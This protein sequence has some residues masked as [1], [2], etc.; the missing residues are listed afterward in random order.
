MRR[1]IILIT[2]AL[3][4]A[5]VATAQKVTVDVVNEPAAA[6]FRSLITQT[7]KNFVYSSDILEGV[8]VTVKAKDRPLKKVLAEMF[9]GTGIEWKI[10]GDNVLLK[11]GKPAGKKDGAKGR[12]VDTQRQRLAS[13]QSMP[14]FLDEVTVES[15]LA[16]PPVETTEVGAV[17]VRGDEVV[18]TPALLGEP[19]VIRALHTQP[20]ISEGTEG[21][22]GMYVHGGNADENLIMLDNVPLYQMNHFAGLFSPFN[23]DIVRNID[24][25]KSSIPAKF[26]GRLSSAMDVS[27]ISGSTDGHHGSARLGLTSGAFSISGPI[28]SRTTYMAGIRRSWYDVLTV[29]LMAIGNSL[30]DDKTRAQ[31]YFTDFNAKVTHRFSDRATGFAGV[32]LGDDYVKAG[33]KGDIY[34]FDN[35]KYTEDEK[36]KIH[37]GNFMAKA[38]LN[39]RLNENISAEFTAACSRYFSS[40]ESRDTHTSLDENDPHTTEYRMK[41][42]N[43]VT[44]WILRGDFNWAVS[45]NS[46]IRYGAGYVRH[47][48]LPQSISSVNVID[49]VIGEIRD[50]A[51]VC[52]A[53]EFNAYIED[54]WRVTDKVR[55]NAGLHG[56]L[57]YIGGKLKHGLSPRLSLGYRP[58]DN[59]AIKAAYSRTV[60]YVHQMVQSYLSL[61]TDHWIPVGGNFKPETADKVALGGYWQSPD[62][63]YGLSAEGYYKWM[64]NLLDYRNEYYLYPPSDIGD[65]RLTQ[66]RGTA[67]GIDLKVE[68]LS[69]RITGHIS[70]SLAWADRTFPDINGGRTFPARFDNRHTINVVVNWNMS[71]KVQLNAVWTGHSGNR[72]TLLTQNW[73]PP[74]FD[75]ETWNYDVPLREDINHY[76]LP[77]YHRL[78]LSCMVRNKRGYWT[79]G[80]Y[81]AYNHRNVVA[82]WQGYKDTLKWNPDYG[83]YWSHSRPTFYNMRLLPVIPSISYTWKF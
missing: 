52:G 62:M 53:N 13:V 82:V 63:K 25:Y 49:G 22:A 56:S 54:L 81:N 77:F 42:R 73:E 50:S 31:Y 67:K 44:D 71:R 30:S 17:K 43:N 14:Q 58:T 47:S 60:Q 78:D 75:G 76:Q 29:P 61:P 57:F 15:Q 39:Y 46:H 12:Y 32:Y 7:G 24:F 36:N 34:N 2:I 23:P 35:I 72:F 18:K 21:M 68:K 83:L 74:S 28:G 5:I 19:D 9:D 38:G 48:F 64:H 65:T 16:T 51:S 11:R 37:W 27:L 70:Y 55:I 79:F 69:G 59:V 8:K 26:D 41:M 40:M 1:G 4:T 45:D 10:A 66:G 3:L 33:S 80:L 20:G 6:V